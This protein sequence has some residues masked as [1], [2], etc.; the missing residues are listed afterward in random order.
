[1]G[2]NCFSSLQV[3][4]LRVALLDD[5]GAP[6]AGADALVVS[7]A[8]IQ[9]G[10]QVQV[11]EGSN[12]EQKN[13][14]GSVCLTYQGPDKI[15]GVNLTAQLCTL[16]HELIALMTGA[17][18][19]VVGGETRGFALPG[20]NEEL[21]RRVSVEAWALA[22]DGD[23]QAVD[24]G[25]PLYQRYIWPSVSWLFGDGTLEDNPLAVPLTGRGR[26]N[27][28]FGNGPGNDLP[29]GVYTTAMGVFT[30]DGELPV[31]T[32]GTQTLVAS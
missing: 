19:A 20:P 5:A 10:W 4:R 1:M 2:F 32:C 25:N 11:S 6:D 16:D 26:G 3:C 23:Q 9:I 15:T 18:L 17:N 7:D 31:A 24:T 29:W 28:G 22:W 13:G 30:D 14:C 8:L 21:T 27:A 12:F